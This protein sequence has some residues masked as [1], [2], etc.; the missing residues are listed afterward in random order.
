MA[1]NNDI[2]AQRKAEKDRFRRKHRIIAELRFWLAGFLLVAILLSVY[3]CVLDTKKA[4]ESLSL[5]A[6]D[7][8]RQT[9]VASCGETSISLMAFSYFF[10]DHYY[11]I[12]ESDSF[13][14]DYRAYGLDP[15]KPLKESE[16][17]ALRSWFEELADTVFTTVEATVQYAELARQNSDRLSA[18]DEAAIAA[19]LTSLEESAKS[20]GRSLNDYL[21]YRYGSGMQREDVESAL[22][23]Y[24]LAQSKYNAVIEE[25]GDCS[26]DELSKYYRDHREE[27]DSIDCICYRFDEK[28]ADA[29]DTEAAFVACGTA[30]D[31]LALV[32]KDLPLAGCPEDQISGVLDDCQKRLQYGGEGEF[33][34]W[35]FDSARKNGDIF[36]RHSDGYCEVYYL[37]RAGG[38]YSFPSANVRALLVS[39]EVYKDE[40]VTKQAAELLYNAAIKNGTEEYF[41]ALVKE[42][43]HDLNTISYGGVYTDIVPGDLAEEYDKWIFADG[44]KTG[45]IGMVEADG[46]YS[47]F[48]YTGS[49][50]PCWQV[51]ARNA[52]TD[53]RVEAF[54]E[55]LAQ[56]LPISSF[57]SAVYTELADDLAIEHDRLYDVTEANGETLYTTKGTV[58]VGFYCCL[59]IGILLLAATVW[60]FVYTGM[61]KKKYG[62]N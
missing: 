10:Y 54:E 4:R 1:S 39:L 53:E 55:D 2:K 11:T 38:K 45:D 5:A 7:T 28:R 22:R 21:D 49:G 31:F 17:T 9:T 60:A 14:R 29:S 40:E 56:R 26:D 47:I 27:L 61:L 43:S 20:E 41:T 58:Y 8:Y 15:T 32:E 50:D 35:A 57:T 30:D 33:Y 37:V 23:L 59:A 12:A 51:S 19:K 24:Y 18:E 42:N 44:R 46:S 25:L 13:I 34:D 16:Y 52:L 6:G 62:Y 48:Y 36:T 3:V